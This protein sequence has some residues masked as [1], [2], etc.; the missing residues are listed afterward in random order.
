MLGQHG[1]DELQRPVVAAGPRL[2]GELVDNLVRDHDVA[3]FGVGHHPRLAGDVRRVREAVGG[4][5]LPQ[6][7]QQKRL[8]GAR[9]PVH[10]D[11]VVQVGS[12]RMASSRAF[13]SSL[14]DWPIADR[15]HSRPTFSHIAIHALSHKKTAAG[16]RNQMFYSSVAPC[17]ALYVYTTDVQAHCH[18]AALPR[19]RMV[20]WRSLHL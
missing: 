12:T 7:R 3:D 19:S 16:L 5:H 1:L 17:L 10:D 18:Y 13:T 14:T 9:R 11:V 6:Q 20:T 8:P 2:L 15:S 4:G